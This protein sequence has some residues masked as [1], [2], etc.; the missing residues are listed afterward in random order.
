MKQN[1]ETLKKYFETGDKPTQ[2]QYSD[3]IDSY[4]DSK[5][6]EGEANRRFVID[7]MGEV[8][9]VKGLQIPE[10]KEGINITIDNSDPLQPIINSTGGGGSFVPYIGAISDVNLG[11][12]LI[13]LGK[14]ETIPNKAVHRL[15]LKGNDGKPLFRTQ[16]QS[17]HSSAPILV[18]N[19][20]SYGFGED[21]LQNNIGNDDTAFGRNSLQNNEAIRSNGV[22]NNSLRN[23][24][25][26]DNNGIGYDSLLNNDGSNSNGMGTGSLRNSKGSNNN[27]FGRYVMSGNEGDRNNGYGSNSLELNKGNNN[28]A[29]GHTSLRVNTSNDSSGHG[30]EN[31]ILNGGDKA[32]SVGSGGMINNEGENNSSL[33]FNSYANFDEDVS[34]EKSASAVF[35]VSNRII[36]TA[37]GYGAVG[38]HVNLKL[39]VLVGNTPPPIIPK[40]EKVFKFKVIDEN[41]LDSLIGGGFQNGAGV[42]K[43]VSQFVYNNST[44]LGANSKPTKSNQVVLGDD[45]IIEVTTTGDYIST[46]AGK[47]VILK[48]PDGAKDYRVSIDNSGNIVTTQII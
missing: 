10:Y 31:L 44:S 17:P 29:N 18:F 8:I 13:Q 37:H 4:V 26:G 43:I 30:F 15:Y 33:G 19:P 9:V 42:Y 14:T 20:K 28:T 23:N 25:G 6:P 48:T 7:E 36:C 35:N 12:N 34:K 21:A 46:N 24:K 2:E 22:G 47:G 11:N 39:K 5:Q 38:E 45:N 27:G 40:G 16:E 41:T 1:K 3:L 32:S